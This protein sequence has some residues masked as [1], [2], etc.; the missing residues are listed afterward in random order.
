MPNWFVHDKWAKKAGIDEFIAYYVN[1]N[2]DYGTS[3]AY[4]E[5]YDSS[6]YNNNENIAIQQLQFFYQKDLDNANDDQNSYVKAFILHHLLDYFRETRVN[7]NDIN[8]VFEK[9]LQNKVIIE[10]SDSKGNKIDFQKEMGEIFNLLRDNKNELYE[11]LRG[12]Y[13]TDSQNPI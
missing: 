3:W 11:D 9:F 2:I 8:L 5:N 13:F 10:I 7:I 4:P 12:K 1:R 6:H